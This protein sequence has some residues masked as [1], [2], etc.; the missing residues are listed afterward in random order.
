MPVRGAAR[1]AEPL[2]PASDRLR[3]ELAGVLQASAAQRTQLLGQ[4]YLDHELYPLAEAQFLAVG[5]AGPQGLAASA[6]LAYTRWR[7]G[8]QAGG[9]EQLRQLVLQHPEQPRARALLAL[10]ALDLNDLATARDQL[11]IIQQAAPGDPAT[12]LA[13]GQ[14]QAAQ[15]DYLAAVASFQRALD[16]APLAERSDYALYL[17][18][19]HLDSAIQVCEVARPAAEIA[20]T[21]APKRSAAWVA[22]AQA[23]LACAD[24][25]GANSA[26]QQALQLDPHDPEA[27]Y[28]AG[29]VLR[30]LGD[31]AGARQALIAA[32]DAQPGSRWQSRAER[33]LTL[34]AP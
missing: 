32:A 6:F 33:E 31:R 9:L 3:Q 16:L 18:R 22:L 23:R 15:R 19:F 5:S 8:D 14:W 27:H 28:Q 2:V 4:L 26:I 20:S 25:T 34:L 10:V 30:A 29:R 12:Y 24:P 1:L 21:A 11:A 13:W 17:A 7:A